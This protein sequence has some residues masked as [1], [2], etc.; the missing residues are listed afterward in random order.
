MRWFRS[1]LE[2]LIREAKQARQ[3]QA[4]LEATGDEILERTRVL[5]QTIAQQV[6]RLT[7]NARTKT[8]G[9]CRP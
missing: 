4:F 3:Q 8:G 1:R 7:E 9:R 6:L 2:N 5:S